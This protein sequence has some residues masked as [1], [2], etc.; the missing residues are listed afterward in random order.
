M[1]PAEQAQQSGPLSWLIRSWM[2]SRIDAFTSVRIFEAILS[3]VENPSSSSPASTTFSSAMLISSA[4][5][6]FAAASF[7][8]DRSAI[9]LA[10]PW[11]YFTPT[12]LR[13][14][15][16]WCFAVR[17]ARY[18]GSVP[19]GSSTCRRTN[20]ITCSGISSSAG[21][22]PMRWYD[23]NISSSA[24]RCSSPSVASAAY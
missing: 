14:R 19:S 16:R 24:S 11:S 10:S 13:T 18:S 8:I 2:P 23:F 9:R 17:S 3:N 1:R 6:F 21:K 12:F 22:Q 7:R 4:G 5:R 20:S 15:P